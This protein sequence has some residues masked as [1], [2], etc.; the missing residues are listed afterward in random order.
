MKVRVRYF[1]LKKPLELM[2][3]FWIESNSFMKS[4]FGF[5]I[6]LAIKISCLN[7][8]DRVLLGGIKKE[9]ICWNHLSVNN[10]DEITNFYIFPF[11]Y[12]LNKVSIHQNFSALFISLFVFLVTELSN[13]HQVHNPHRLHV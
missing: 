8:A 12:I 4:C 10:S 13:I 6:T 3:L 1:D 7:V 5:E 9:H 11:I 2:K